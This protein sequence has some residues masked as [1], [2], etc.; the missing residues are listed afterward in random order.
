MIVFAILIFCCIVTKQT[1]SSLHCFIRLVVVSCIC[2]FHF[3]E[4]ARFILRYVY[5]SF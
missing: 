1:T 3:S 5:G 4:G 2:V